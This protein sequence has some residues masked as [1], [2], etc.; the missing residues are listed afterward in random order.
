MKGNDVA[1]FM[2]QPW[3]VCCYT[4]E[5]CPTIGKLRPADDIVQFK[6]NNNAND[7]YDDNNNN[8]C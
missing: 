7:D 4:Q 6:P 8:I 5:I 3:F 2:A 1:E